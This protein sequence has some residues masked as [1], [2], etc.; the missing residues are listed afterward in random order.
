LP[1]AGRLRSVLPR[2]SA[3]GSRLP[4]LATGLECAVSV[5]LLRLFL[6]RAGEVARQRQGSR[7]CRGTNFHAGVGSVR[8]RDPGMNR[9]F[10][11]SELGTAVRREVI[12]GITTFA[13]MAY[14]IVVNPKILEAAGM[15]FGPSMVATI[16]TAFIGTL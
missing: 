8:K 13:T 4:Q 2:S 3:G 6:A 11:L 12:A 7:H 15:P 1:H 9:F 5:Y 14:I 16:L 10:R